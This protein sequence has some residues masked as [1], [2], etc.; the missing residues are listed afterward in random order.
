VSW[1]GV[2]RNE[3]SKV[4]C[5][6]MTSRHYGSDFIDKPKTLGL[7]IYCPIL[8]D[9]EIGEY[10]FLEYMKTGY[11]CRRLAEKELQLTVTLRNSSFQVQSSHVEVFDHPGSLIRSTVT[12]TPI[13]TRRFHMLSDHVSDRKRRTNFSFREKGL[14]QLAAGGNFRR[15]AVCAVQTFRNPL[16][17]PMMHM[18]VRYYLSLG[19]RVIIYDRFGLHR[20][21]V[22]GMFHVPGFDY[23]PYTVYQLAQP[24]KYDQ[25]KVSSSDFQFR[26]FYPL[27]KRWGYTAELVKDTADQD[28]DKTRTY[29]HCRVEYSHLDTILYVDTDELFICPEVEPGLESQRNAQRILM[30]RFISLGIQEMRFVRLP[31]AGRLPPWLP[32]KTKSSGEVAVN[33]T[34]ECMKNAY[35]SGRLSSMLACWS[36]ASSWDDFMKS[37]DMA[38]VCPFHYNHWSCDG[39]RAGGRDSGKETPRCRCKVALDMMNGYSF[40]PHI[41]KCHLMHLNDNKYRFQSKRLKKKDGSTAYDNGDI[42][43][44]NPSST[45]LFNKHSQS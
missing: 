26:T 35:N 15:H 37:A 28:A 30:D 23:Y 3:S 10:N 19:W 32:A 21:F 20:D 2:S 14:N 13:A 18:F 40:K 44:P 11:Y 45:L 24:D 36:S 12:T 29:D 7:V 8:L 42:T 41:D 6:Y 25:S 27:E 16:S 33:V 17:G 31:Y 4:H 9:V 22:K 39:Q 34:T 1:I 38:G 43:Q 5:Y